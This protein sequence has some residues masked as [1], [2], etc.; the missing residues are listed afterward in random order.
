MSEI[1]VGLLG[2]GNAGRIFHA[3]LIMSEPRMTLCQIGSRQFADKKLPKGVGGAPIDEVLENPDIDLIVV[4][5]PNDSHAALAKQ[6]LLNGKHVVVDKPFALDANEAAEVVQLANQHE[7]LLSVFQNRRWDGGFLTARKTMEKGVL[8]PV[9][10]GEFHFDRYSPEIKDRWREWD[11]PGAGILYDLGPHLLDQIFHMFGMPDALTANVARQRPGAIVEDFFH[12]VLEFGTS[13]IVAH[14]SSL[15]PDHAPRI[16]LYGQDASFFQFGFDGQ[17]E[18]LKNG[19]RPGSPGW[20]ETPG[21]YSY[22]LEAN[23]SRRDIPL[24][25]GQYEAF[26]AGIADAIDKATRPDVTGLQALKVMRVLDAAAQSARTGHR[27]TL[28]TTPG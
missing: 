27:V 3:P 9:S 28:Q 18:A 5:T 26:Y 11:T 7:K 4:A 13:R 12:I 21:G 8:G 22:L 15:M 23:G 25:L 2:Y 16:A 19:S 14:A 20:G 10:Y 24:S 6:A 1:R 17:E